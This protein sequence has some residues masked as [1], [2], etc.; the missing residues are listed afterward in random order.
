MS[1]KSE[2][3]FKSSVRRYKFFCDDPDSGDYVKRVIFKAMDGE[4][5]VGRLE[6]CIFNLEDMTYDGQLGLFDHSATTERL[7]SVIYGGHS[8]LEEIESSG[9]RPQFVKFMKSSFQV[10]LEGILD[11]PLS[12]SLFSVCF[13]DD[14]K[15]I[16][17]Y[18]GRGI[19]SHLMGMTT[20]FR[21]SVDVVILQ[22][23]P[24]TPYEH[25]AS[26]NMS[27]DQEN[28][29]VNSDQFYDLNSK[30]QKRLNTFYSKMGF[31]HFSLDHCH[32]M[33]MTHNG[34]KE[35]HNKE[36]G[37]AISAPSLAA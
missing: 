12:E 7:Y 32:W 11:I 34:L 10:D 8:L 9:F 23:F 22:S 6:G 5:E 36:R 28:A 29:F 37:E 3:T 4:K 16:P 33:V 2:I 13:V 25:I 26:L 35:L 1:D 24:Q 17:E 18:R 21:N 31:K 15:V 27:R 30:A 19:G 20:R 14:I